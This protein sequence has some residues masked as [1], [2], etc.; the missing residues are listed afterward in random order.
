MLSLFTGSGARVFTQFQ[1]FM[2]KLLPERSLLF[3]QDIRGAGN[4]GKEYAHEGQASGWQERGDRVILI[5]E[6]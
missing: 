1:L 5:E 3:G 4:I 2:A 6:K